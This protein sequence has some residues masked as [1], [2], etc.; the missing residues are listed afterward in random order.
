MRLPTGGARVA[1][2]RSVAQDEPAPTAG[3]KD[4]APRD[5]I[6]KTRGCEVAARVK[7]E[8]AERIAHATR[9]YDRLLG[10]EVEFREEANPRIADRAV[11]EVTARTK[12]GHVRAQGAAADHRGALDMAVDRFSRQLARM[13][14]RLVDREHG[15]DRAAPPVTAPSVVPDADGVADGLPR[16]VRL[17][18]F[19]LPPMRAEE[20]AVQ[21]E[22]LAHDFYVF[23]NAGTGQVNV[24][25]RRRDGDLGLIEPV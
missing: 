14:S 1:A 24:I 12:G 8:A 23:T 3:E 20:A 22:L 16:I 18:R 2:D 11:V 5:I 21:L 15:R 17:K 9:F 13:K 7:E 10:V 25:Y 4:E 19:E 6:V